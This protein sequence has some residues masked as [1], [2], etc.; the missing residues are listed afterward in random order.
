MDIIESK[1][2]MRRMFER[3]AEREVDITESVYRIFLARVDEAR[4]PMETV[5]QRMRGRMLEQVMMLLMGDTEADYLGFETRMHRSY[6]ANLEL[7]FGLFAAI[8][9]V[10]KDVFQDDWS[11]E[12][13]IAFNETVQRLMRDI[14][15][16]EG[17]LAD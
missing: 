8:K 11:I 6:G 9:D 1:A 14:R 15:V 7:Y 2:R 16:L 3:L 5:D 17:E 12:D 13:E 4:E 10:V